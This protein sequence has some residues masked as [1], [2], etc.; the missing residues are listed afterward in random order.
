VLSQTMLEVREGELSQSSNDERDVVV[1]SLRTMDLSQPDAERAWKLVPT[2]EGFVL[3]DLHGTAP[4]D[5]WATS[6]GMLMFHFDGTDWS[7]HDL[8]EAENAVTTSG[9]ARVWA[10]TSEDVWV[11]GVSTIVGARSVTPL[12]HYDG[13]GWQT[14]VLGE[15][16]VPV[17]VMW[18]SGSND[19][20]AMGEG[21]D[22]AHF[23]GDTWSPSSVNVPRK[24]TAMVGTGPD[25]VWVG[26][27]DGVLDHY[28]G[29][30]WNQEL[31]RDGSA[32]VRAL[33]G[34]EQ[35]GIWALYG[36]YE[37]GMLT[38][39]LLSRSAAEGSEWQR[40][41]ER[42]AG[43]DSQYTGLTDLT[44]TADGEIWGAGDA[45]MRLR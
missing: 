9:L 45:V 29:A 43:E 11:A 15:T 28:D 21:S 3:G 36:K 17:F 31:L 19:V 22:A 25:D 34:N 44:M 14:H 27:L 12:F 38:E 35:H 20:W 33:V 2:P 39:R 30:T 37:N 1:C 42:V 32:W 41:S 16:G 18:A 5:L 10:V 7:L 40:V 23:D 13:R 6:G 8:S 24:L 4:D 26:G